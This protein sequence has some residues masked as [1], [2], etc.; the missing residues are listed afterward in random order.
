MTLRKSNISKTDTKK[1]IKKSIKLILIIF[2]CMSYLFLEGNIGNWVSQF[3]NT[4][5][6]LIKTENTLDYSESYSLDEIPEYNDSPY[7]VINNNIPDFEDSEITTETYY[8]Y[9]DLDYLGR[10]GVAKACIGA[11]TLT[12]EERGNISS[13][14]P[15]G[16]QSIKADDVDGGWLYN[17]SHLIANC[18]GGPCGREGEE[19]GIL[20]KDLITGTRYMNVEGMEPFELMVRDYIYETNNHVMYRVTPIYESNSKNLVAN[21][22]EMEAYSVEDNGEGIEFNVYCFNVQPKYEINYVDGK[23]IE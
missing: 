5:S 18:L 15:S 14:Y 23:L 21:G 16:W 6:G 4:T 22:V 20:E 7:V 2:I 11:D 9:S 1:K 10:C 13:V 8:E 17:R 19:D 12:Q 3:K